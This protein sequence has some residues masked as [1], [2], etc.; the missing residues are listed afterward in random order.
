LPLYLTQ[1]LC[2]WP[3]ATRGEQKLQKS[4]RVW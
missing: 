2:N 3:N 1:R 4:L